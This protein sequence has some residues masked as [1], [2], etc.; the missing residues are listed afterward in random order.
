MAPLSA[1]DYQLM[2]AHC[3]TLRRSPGAQE[4]QLRPPSFSRPQTL[5]AF[6]LPERVYRALAGW[7]PSNKVTQETWGLYNHPVI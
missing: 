3:L 2:R 7:F 5:P 6:Q 1:Q 4:L